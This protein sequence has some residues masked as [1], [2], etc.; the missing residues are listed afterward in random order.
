M[1]HTM[2][3]AS[4]PLSPMQEG[5]LFQCLSSPGK[6]VDIEQVV[7]RV[8]EE[9]DGECFRKAWEHVTARHATLRTSL[10]WED[11]DRPVQEVQAAVAVPFEEQDW[12]GLPAGQQQ[13]RL[14]VF[15]AADRHTG[16][17][18]RVAP[19]M[20]I[21]LFRLGE[22]EYTFVWSLHHVVADGRSFPIVLDEVFTAYEAMARGAEPRLAPPRAY[23]EYIN[24]LASRDR[25]QEAEFWRTLLQDVVAPTPIVPRRSG[26]AGSDNR[27]A[28][29]EMRLSRDATRSLAALAR[30]CDVRLSTLVQG[31]WAITLS[32]YSGEEDVIFGATRACRRGTVPG[33]DE[34]VGVFINT[35]PVRVQVTPDTKLRS[36]LRALR[37]QQLAVR[38]FEHTPLADVQRCSGVAPG[39]SLFDSIIVF[40]TVSLNAML[41]ARAEG[42]TRRDC[43]LREN[44]GYPMTLYANG[45]P[46][47]SLRITSEGEGLTTAGAAR[48]LGYVRTVLEGMAAHPEATL[49]ELPALSEPE[50]QL[51]LVEWN[52]TRSEYRR[53]RLVHEFV[54][55]QVDRTP[56]SV[57]LVHGDEEVT[58]GD[59]EVRV[60]RLAAHLRRL[61]VGREA[62]VGVCVNRCIDMVVAMLAVLKVGGAYVP[63]DPTYPKKRLEFMLADADVRVVV[64][65]ESLTGTALASYTGQVVRLDSEREAIAAER[66]IR[67]PSD[68]KPGDLAYVIY[69][70]GSTGRPKGVMVEH[71]NV[72]SFFAGMD[73]RIAHDPSG[74][75]LA[76]TSLS[77]DISVLELL[78][79]LTRGFKVVIQSG[80]VRCGAAA[81]GSAP[82]LGARPMEFSLFYFASDEGDGGPDK[83][84]LLMDG[85]RF[86]D[87]Y[88]FAAVWTPERHFHAFGGLYPNPSVTSAAIAAVTR[89][90][91][92]RA[93]SCV[94]PLHNPIRVVEEWSVVD[95]LSNGRVG[96]SFAS[97]WQ[98]NDFVL[99]PQHYADAKR[100][101]VEG[102]DVVRRL[103]RGEALSFAGPRGQVQVRTLPRPIQPELPF[104][105]TSAG[106]PETFQLAGELGGSVL[107]HLLGQSVDEL[108]EKITLYRRA[109][110]EAGHAGEGHV[111]LMLHTF[112]GK[113]ESFVRERVREPLKGYLRSATSLIK[114][115][116]SAFPTFR[117]TSAAAGEAVDLDFADLSEEDLD[118]LLE[119]AVARYYETSGLFGTP[120][121]CL[122]MV[123]RLREVGVDE[124]A[125]LVDFGVA[126]DLVLDHLVDLNRLRELDRVA[127][128]ALPKDGRSIAELILR[129]GVT[130]LQ[131]TPSLAT[132]LSDDPDTRSALR[133]VRQMLVGG[134]VLTPRLASE[135]GAVVG[136]EVINMYGPTE[137]TI[138]SSTHTVRESEGSVPIGRPIANTQLYV[139]D[140]RLRPVPVGVEGELYI[141]GDG[142]ARGYRNRSGQ[143]AERFIRHPFSE[144][145]T[146]RL[147]RTGDRVRYREDGI[148]EF[149]GRTDRQVKIRGQRVELGE[150]ERVLA[151]HPAVRE[152]VAVTREDP[153]GLTLVAYW[154]PV[155]RS[156]PRADE[157]RQYLME[158]LPQVMVPSAVIPLE[159]LPL[160]PN[161]KLNRAALPAP[162]TDGSAKVD[163]FVRPRSRLEKTLAGI[164]QELLDVERVGIHDNFFALGGHSLTAIQIA[165]RIRRLLNM[166]LPLRALFEAPTIAEL[167]AAIERG[168]A[169]EEL[170]A[171]GA[172]AGEGG[173]SAAS[174]APASRSIGQPVADAKLG[175]DEQGKPAWFVPDPD[176]PGK[177]LQVGRL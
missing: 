21:A 102:I 8:R 56:D 162:V 122:A 15:L 101:M 65:Q 142:V 36:W 119:Q 129:H 143:T 160:T 62:L 9:L 127:R 155:G 78:W 66:E 135:L 168:S 61:G 175:W 17:N 30:D 159:S 106:H 39:A 112:V 111:T 46:A 157:L 3:A 73:E 114:R 49:S 103:W 54:E 74:V 77:F 69:T 134:E 27:R 40:D 94:L 58:Y 110:S 153:G 14:E 95:N 133:M 163:G 93:G 5:M 4:Y 98:P 26:G 68:A 83:Y 10:R 125:C 128:T 137:T 41:R 38:P 57:A 35:L 44:T 126:S 6:G 104:W 138:W 43:T 85:A 149:L 80:E 124:I 148:V 169:T 173:E 70:S 67:V 23:V 165:S 63:L 18:P 1:K 31:A 174:G 22:Q 12:R 76:V 161:G 7:C 99:M 150:V 13:R 100:V 34:M 84:R 11:V 29:C 170:A 37:A 139:L 60:N 42:W 115:F 107:T 79:T 25:K 172:G 28:E 141:G 130:H 59:L 171:P 116:A 154:V 109:W 50:A 32:R 72:V 91:Q 48:M 2:A 96:V 151:G 166:T 19:L 92:I 123:D 176:R 121:R 81:G 82:D 88:G 87:Q 152:A 158:E 55:D 108:A 51:Q 52:A 53:D 167:A 89:R 177:Y 136:G 97:G 90:V 24:W 47:L 132:V 33:A 147:Y 113:N 45:E 131:C 16:F 20:R 71:R 144:D 118:A 146:A 164:W 105:I 120:E 86:A 140:D 145:A 156:R 64:T 75:W 117:S